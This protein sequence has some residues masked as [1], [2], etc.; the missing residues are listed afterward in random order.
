M[1]IMYLTGK[2]E[3]GK[4][5]TLKLLY[6]IFCKNGANSSMKVEFLRNDIEPGYIYKSIEKL[7]YS[8]PSDRRESVQNIAVKFT[9]NGKS[10]LIYTCG[11]TT[12]LIK[13]GIELAKKHQVDF[14]IAPTHKAFIS[15]ILEEFYSYNVDFI[16]KDIASKEEDFLSCNINQANV[17]FLRVQQELQLM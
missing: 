9:F 15:Y 4:T 6:C 7:Q 11:D 10:F 13:K 1:R 3:T 17:L 2:K 14:Y 16:E 8:K 12:K 5:I